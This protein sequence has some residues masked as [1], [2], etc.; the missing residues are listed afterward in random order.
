MRNR[1]PN[2]FIVGPPHT[3]TTSLW[4]YLGEHPDVVMSKLKEPS[5]FIDFNPQIK[6]MKQ[7]MKQFDHAKNEKIIGEASPNYIYSPSAAKR[8]H[9]FN[10][11]A[12]IIIMLR[13][14]NKA[15]LSWMSATFRHPKGDK[16]IEEPHW[17][18][19]DY[20]TNIARFKRVFPK[21]QI[22]LIDFNEFSKD[23]LKVYKRILKFLDIKD[24][25]RT[26]FPIHNQGYEIKSKF[27]QGLI[28]RYFY[29]ENWLKSFFKL[30]ISRE[31][32]QKIADLNKKKTD[33]NRSFFG[34]SGLKQ[35]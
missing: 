24:D 29:G 27:F 34:N 26:D 15:V 10:P 30:F 33:Q 14:P 22:L 5:F 19:Y 28:Q 25:G 11:K 20:K 3:G 9:R 1:K 21:K 31:T 18:I 32:A 6:T 12:K 16:D 23:T 4:R 7:Y 8:I 35:R 13:D 17:D 2:L